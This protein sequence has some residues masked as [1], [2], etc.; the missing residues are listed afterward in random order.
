[1]PHDDNVRAYQNSIMIRKK[2]INRSQKPIT[3]IE[4]VDKTALNSKSGYD[5]R[6]TMENNKD[7]VALGY[8]GKKYPEYAGRKRKQ[9][10]LIK[11]SIR[12]LQKRLS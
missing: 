7:S 2:Q 4:E 1:M 8:D 5:K 3:Y 9:N 12:I 11:K 6:T 10:K